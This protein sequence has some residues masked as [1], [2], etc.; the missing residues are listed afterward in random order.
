MTE[1][2]RDGGIKSVADEAVNNVANDA[3]NEVASEAANAD[4][5][6]ETIELSTR[7]TNDPIRGFY[8]DVS[9][10]TL[11]I[12][13]ASKRHSR[14]GY[15]HYFRKL[16]EDHNPLIVGKNLWKALE[17]HED[18]MEEVIHQIPFPNWRRYVDAAAYFIPDGNAKLIY[19]LFESMEDQEHPSVIYTR[20]HVLRIMLIEW[21]TELRKTEP[22]FGGKAVEKDDK[23]GEST[24]ESTGGSDLNSD[25]SDTDTA[26]SATELDSTEPA[27]GTTLPNTKTVTINVKTKYEQPT[28]V[29]WWLRD[30]LRQYCLLCTKYYHHMFEKDWVEEHFDLLPD[31]YRL[32]IRLRGCFNDSWECFRET[33]RLLGQAF[34]IDPAMDGVVKR[35]ATMYL[36]EAVKHIPE[37][38]RPEDEMAHLMSELEKKVENLMAAGM[39][40]EA[41][42]VLH[43]AERLFQVQDEM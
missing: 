12:I 24:V 32:A 17:G 14:A 3:S 6:V 4:E 34:G 22:V 25:E 41:G 15:A 16:A 7:D 9:P 38:V 28:E 10:W 19:G 33:G 36:D 43:D 37:A 20:M 35:Y 26:A 31:T 1:V 8:E 5:A 29:F 23:V 18:A 42:Q 27:T 30:Q 39:L 13:A 11:K 21:D 40:E 2:I